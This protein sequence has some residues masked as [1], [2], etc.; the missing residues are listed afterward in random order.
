MIVKQEDRHFAHYGTPRH[1]GR[2]PWG[3]GGNETTRNRSFL[4]AVD[5]LKSKGLSDAEIAKGM[6]IT[7]TQLKA[8]RS[9]AV[10]AKKIDQVRQAQRLA[11]KG[12]S[13]VAIGERMEL[14]ESTVRSLL[15]PGRIDKLNVLHATSSKIKE[16]VEKSKYVDIGVGVENQMGISKD[17]LATAVAMLEDEGYKKHYIKVPQATNPGKFTT[18]KVLTKDDVPYSEVYR[19]RGEIKQIG[20][21][22]E[23]GGRTYLGLHPPMSVNSKRIGINYAEDGGTAADGVIYVRPGVKDVSIGS[24]KYAQVRIAVDGTHYLKGMAMYKDDLPEDVDLVFNTNKSRSLSKKDVMKEMTDDPDNP[25][26][27]QIKRQIVVKDSSGVEHL[28]SAMNVVNEEGDWDKWSKTVSSQVLSKQ[29]PALAKSQLDMTFERRL[30]EYEAISKL[31]NPTV[32]KKLLNTFADSTDSAAVHL[33]AAAFPSQATKVLL[34]IKS[35][36]PTEVFAPTFSN[37]TRVA[38][39]RFPHAGTFEIPELTVNNRNREALKVIGNAAPDAIG[40]HHQVA[41]HLSGADFD[42]DHVIVIPNNRKQIKTTPALEGLKGFDPNHSYPPYDGMRTIDGGVYHAATGKVDYEGRAPVSSRKQQEMGK[43]TNLIADM[44]IHGADA[45]DLARAVRHS[46]VVID[47]EKHNLDFKAS[48]AANGI[49]Q[50]K[51]KYQGNAR[52]GASTLI[53]KAGSRIDVPVRKPRPASQG[54]PIDPVTGKKV[55]VETGE[56]HVNRKGQTVPSMQRSEKLVETDDAGTLSSGTRIEKVYVEHSN[57]LKALANT[58]R[59]EMVATK[60]TPYSKS[61]KATYS[62][63]VA[64]LDAKLNLA[65]KNAPLERQA[66]AIASAVVSQKRQANP[67]M[68]AEDV[69]K[70]RNQAIAEARVRTGA[71]KT[72]IEPTQS[73][74]DAIQAGAI[75]NHKLEQIL[76]NSDLDAIKKL[77]TPKQELLMTTTKKARATQMLASGYTQA[78]VAS[79]LGVSLT[80]LKTGISKG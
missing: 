19:N 72:R 61:A 52:S 27:A 50:L 6:N 29:S 33:K 80:T 31:T 10:N 54:G 8:R 38:L 77:A 4:D 28:T 62:N 26:G 14:N 16:E 56:T 30:D 15:T 70:I 69:T 12:L 75:S 11:D 59:K 18:I 2:Y 68:V 57:K 17:K 45:D 55:Y 5:A 13:N 39:V 24:S 21:F 67:D 49:A 71:G 37:G 78:E 34:P 9:I 48:A 79:A 60:S 25:F 43:I 64:T 47:S 63:E 51:A 1:S 32:R 7:T 22:S 41:E 65:L 74:W 66:Q 53:T 42:G 44:S 76:T 40:I 58:A 3:S 36:K 46:M 23:D 73:E 35:M 20:S